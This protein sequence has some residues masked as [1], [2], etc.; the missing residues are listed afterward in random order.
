MV[1][2][3]RN[4]QR[5]RLQYIPLPI[6]GA[7]SVA[8]P[9]FWSRAAEAAEEEEERAAHERAAD[10]RAAR[11]ARPDPPP[12]GPAS[13]TYAGNVAGVGVV[14]LIAEPSDG[15][16]RFDWG[17]TGVRFD[18]G[19]R[20]TS[21]EVRARPNTPADAMDAGRAL[22]ERLASVGGAGLRRGGAW[23]SS[24]VVCVAIAAGVA[25]LAAGLAQFAVSGG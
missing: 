10:E 15:G 22:G 20:P 5:L 24:G 13:G 12:S 6:D 23:D 7:R 8:V 3:A 2:C 25:L 14:S 4:R 9:G 18:W 21:P 16:S 19:S 11:L 17:S 1:A